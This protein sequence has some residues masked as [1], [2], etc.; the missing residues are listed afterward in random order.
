MVEPVS[1]RGAD[2]VGGGDDGRLLRLRVGVAGGEP[3]GDG[4]RLL[5][6][7]CELVL[8]TEV[9]EEELLGAE[10]DLVL[11]DVVAVPMVGVEVGGEGEI[12]ELTVEVRAVVPGV[13]ILV[14]VGGS[15]RGW[16]PHDEVAGPPGRGRR[17]PRVSA[18]AWGE[19]VVQAD[20]LEAAAALAPHILVAGV[21]LP[22]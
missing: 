1:S 2:A 17:G 12:G 19:A 20:A 18:V 11:H 16:G 7:E 8:A 4:G 22:G 21:D 10:A 6:G 3:A 5:G 14:G 9:V 13:V 15:P